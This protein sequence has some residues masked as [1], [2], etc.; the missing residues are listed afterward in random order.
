MATM[1][2]PLS[3]YVLVGVSLL[4]LGLAPVLRDPI[5]PLLIS[6]ASAVAFVTVSAAPD[7]LLR[8]PVVIVWLSIIAGALPI[9]ALSVF[10]RW[11]TGDVY[12]VGDAAILEIYTLHAV[13]GFWTLGP[14]SQFGW[15]HPGPLYFYLLAPFY[16]LSG[17]KTVALHVG[18]F[19]IN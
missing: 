5:T 15:N 8:K 9:A 18:A 7:R 13:R 11:A 12:P 4:G 14:Y 19:S 3:R 16:V 2:T 1:V 17:Q 6:L 10:F